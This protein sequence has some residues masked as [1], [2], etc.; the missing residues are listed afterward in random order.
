MTRI[1][2]ALEQANRER[3]NLGAPVDAIVP[4]TEVAVPASPDLDA[5]MEGLYQAICS[6]LPSDRG[7]IVGF[8]AAHTGAGVSSVSAELA[9]VAEKGHGASVLLVD[10]DLRNGAICGR[11][12][13]KPAT[14]I[15]EAIANNRPVEEAIVQSGTSH[16]YLS[17]LS[18]AG[19]GAINTDSRALHAAMDRLRDDF[20]LII[21]DAP[22]ALETAAGLAISAFADGMVIVVEAEKTRWQVAESVRDAIE[23][24]GGN[25]LGVVLNK[26]HYHIPDFIYKRL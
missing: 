22:P 6:M 15:Q 24:Q 12:G 8:I 2:Q 26:R 20:D 23:K 3:S 17:A 9:R 21:F 16:L 1:Y 10:T 14:G 13:L 11:F 19:S 4:M 5:R 25:V 18:A 7:R